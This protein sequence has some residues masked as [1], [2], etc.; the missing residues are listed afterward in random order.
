M[1][2]C[3]GPAAPGFCGRSVRADVPVKTLRLLVA[4]AAMLAAAGCIVAS[5]LTWISLPD[6]AGGTTSISGWG[7]VTGGQIDGQNIN[8]AMDGFA[9]FRPGAL[10]VVIGGLAV[11][12]AFGIALVAR[13]EKPHRIP[14]SL[15]ALC[16][17]GGL[18][19][20]IVRGASPGDIAGVLGTGEG[21][22]GVGPW[23]T[24]GCSLI[25]VAVA[26][27]VFTGLLDPP[28]PVRHRG[29]QPR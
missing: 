8:D 28:P 20:G 15:L 10:S 16:G 2:A 17:L 12:A 23:L 7:G 26:V 6:G 22:S 14:A 19:W 24:A 21:S 13:G 18:A 9:S 11:L 4:L 3:S 1:P 5:V 27:V 29:I 25:L